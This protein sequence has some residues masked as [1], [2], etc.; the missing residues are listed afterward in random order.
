MH[1]AEIG[2]LGGSGF[3][4]FLDKIKEIKVNTP[5][6]S[7]S[8]EI[9]L[10]EFKG[11]KIA[12]LPRHGKKHSKAPHLINYKA[13]I[14]AMKELGVKRIIAPCAAGS[15]QPH[16][17][18]GEFV[19]CDQ[20]VDRT[21]GRKDTFF[22]GPIVTHISNADPYCNEL[23]QIAFSAAKRLKIS[24]HP[25]G[26]LVI[27]QGP[28]FSTKAESAWFSNLKWD[29]I[30]MTGYPE[31]TLARELEICY[32]NISLITDYD[33]GLINNPKIKPVNTEEVIKVFHKNNQKIKKL[34]LDMLEKIPSAR[35]CLCQSNLKG[36]QI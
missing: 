2:I 20:F 28:R 6:G 16:I 11:K 7:P 32:L 17:K 18:P 9:A 27:I 33:A 35:T 36:A 19:I 34:I 30:N 23:R 31:I 15:L 21:W 12:F 4:S 10:A 8:D 14:W 26:T 5:Y 25:K 3:Y 24:F 13:N 1:Q 29:V 22:E